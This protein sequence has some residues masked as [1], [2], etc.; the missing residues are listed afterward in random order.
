MWQARRPV[1]FETFPHALAC[2][3]AGN[4]L[5]ASEKRVTR[6]KALSDVGVD[7]SNLPNLDFLDAA[8]CALADSYFAIGWFMSYSDLDG[9]LIVV[10]EPK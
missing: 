5:P 2:A 6:R 9:G 8:L 7:V 10:P 3:L 1:C 4:H